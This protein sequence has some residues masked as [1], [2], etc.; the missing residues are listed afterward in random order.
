MADPRTP[1]RREQ[2]DERRPWR[3]EGA[4]DEPAAPD[5]PSRRGN[6][7]IRRPPGSRRFW[8]FLLVL[9][10]LNI[11]LGQ[12]IPTSEDR[13]LDVPYT[14][15]RAQVKAGNVEEVNARNDVIQGEFRKAVKF[16]DEG[17][18]KT[19]ETVRPTFAQDD[20]LLELL[21]EE[22]VEVNARP[23]D[24]GRS[25]LLTLL[26]SFGPFL[27]ILGLLI[28]FLRRS[29]AGG[30]GALALGRS[31]A[32]R[33][34]DSAQR[35]T[36]EDVAGI[37]EVEDELKEIVDFLKNPDRYRKLGAAFPKGVLLSGPPGTGKTLL[38]R[39]VAGEA[40]VPF[41]SL[42]ASEFV[43]MVVGVG[44]S[45]VR[46]L[47]EQAKKAAPAI[48]FIDELDAIGRARGGGGGGYGGG[49]DERE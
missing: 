8:Q 18:E 21:L 45:R 13:R 40:D 4:R 30:G 44:A 31:K 47:F 1:S 42:S 29:G 28:Y 17:P 20:E 48:I 2:S 38:A 11:I 14:F 27:L 6:G 7:G 46:D 19:F 3:V 49:N 34:D 16:E 12:L 22:D 25:L 23:I 41:F 43:E 24:E 33:Y 35:V 5:K 9:L 39:A 10:V 15:F 32:K 37:D 36:F 26:I